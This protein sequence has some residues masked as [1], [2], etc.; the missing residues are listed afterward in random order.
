LL[1]AV[2]Y[3]IIANSDIKTPVLTRQ[4]DL[5]GTALFN[6]ALQKPPAV[7]SKRKRPCFLVS[8]PFGPRS[9]SKTLSLLYLFK[10]YEVIRNGKAYGPVKDAHRRVE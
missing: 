9:H 6:P 7:S 10:F 8:L 2:H 4:R 5:F 3:G 1:F